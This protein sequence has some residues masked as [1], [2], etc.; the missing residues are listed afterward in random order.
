VAALMFVQL[1]RRVTVALLVP[2]AALG[3]VLQSKL[4]VD[5]WM[6]RWVS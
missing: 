3:L 4:T 5:Y 2:L 1:P 6:W